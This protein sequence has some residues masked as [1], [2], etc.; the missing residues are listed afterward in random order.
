[1]Y[2]GTYSGVAEKIPH[3]QRMGFNA[4]ELLPIQ[5]FNEARTRTPKPGNTLPLR[6]TDQS[7]IGCLHLGVSEMA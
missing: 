2:P 6:A 3:L 7:S 4:V 1:M 5:E